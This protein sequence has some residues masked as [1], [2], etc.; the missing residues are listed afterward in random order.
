MAYLSG[1][2]ERVKL[3]T[4]NQWMKGCPEGG[5]QGFLFGLYSQLVEGKCPCPTGCGYSIP[6]TKSHFFSIFVSS[7]PSSLLRISYSRETTFEAYINHLRGIVHKK[8]RRCHKEFCF[9]CGESVNSQKSPDSTKAPNDHALFHCS[10]LQGII[11]GVGLAML[12]QLYHDQLQNPLGS[13]NKVRTSKRRKTDPVISA[14]MIL[15]PDDDDDN[16]LSPPAQGK[17]LKV[18]TG[19]AGDQKEDVSD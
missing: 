18:G 19:Y 13:E 2:G 11:L 4:Q 1:I 5:E 6:R 9:A 14:S 3:M 7:P 15:D 10:N 8:C 16:Y 12:E 17:K